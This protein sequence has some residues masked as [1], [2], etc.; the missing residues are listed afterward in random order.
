MG[1]GGN[2]FNH[3]YLQARALQSTDRSLTACARSLYIDLNALHAVIDRHFC[4][5]FSSGLSGKGS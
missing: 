5:G 4:S 3:A 2:I 1:D